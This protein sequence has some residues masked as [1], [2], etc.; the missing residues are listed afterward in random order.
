MK[1]PI[2]NGKEVFA[3]LS[4]A[5]VMSLSMS[6]KTDA[7]SESKIDL[8]AENAYTATIFNDIRTS[9]YAALA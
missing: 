3:V 6:V 4:M 1:K 7:A 8:A 2:K 9:R 5:T